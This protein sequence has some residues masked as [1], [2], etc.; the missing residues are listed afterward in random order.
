MS[1]PMAR[2]PRLEYPGA[3]CH[4]IARG[5]NRQAIFADDRDR[6]TYLQKLGHYCTEKEVNLLGYCLL[7]NHLH[8]LLET[9]QENLSKL[10]QPLQTSFTL[11]FNRRHRH[12]GHVFEQRYKALVVDRDNY[13]LHVSRYI[14]SGIGSWE[15][16]DFLPSFPLL[17]SISFFS[18]QPKPLQLS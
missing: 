6:T 2:P 10:M 3:V 11:S 16:P 1:P 4:V 18:H 7:S 8:L 12:T 15:R 14:H 5:N 9:P 13:L 17:S